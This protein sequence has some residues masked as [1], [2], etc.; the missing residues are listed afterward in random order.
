[1]I[2]RC[3]DRILDLDEHVRLMGI[4][5]VTPDSFSDGGRFIDTSL[6]I[7]RAM[8]MVREGAEI[9]D[10]GGESTRPGAEPVDADV[11]IA[12]VIPVVE[13]L[14]KVSNVLISIDTSKAAVAEAAC[15]SGADIVNDVTALGGDEAMGKVVATHGVGVVLM[16]MQGEPRTM[17]SA[18][19]YDDLFGEVISYLSDAA[20][21]ALVAGVGVDQ[22]VI[23]PGIGF[24]KT[25]EQNLALIG[26]ADRFVD[27]GY[28]VLVGPSR[29][30]FIGK[31]LDADIDER[32]EGT[33]ATC[34][35]CVS[36]GVRLLRVHDIAAVYRAVRMTEAIMEYA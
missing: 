19:H 21:R 33:L 12:R 26:C 9:I 28:P 23:D 16:H 15:S 6:A 27:A 5:N 2:L 18:P 10:I 1:M 17:Q 3:R 35:W 8:E 30:S 25:L 14:R 4:L 36:C 24:G 13:G 7:E 22:I 11:E 34:V 20:G 31:V 32:L 29:K